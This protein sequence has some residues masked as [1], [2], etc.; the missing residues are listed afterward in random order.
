LREPEGLT[1]REI[2]EVT[3][4]L[5]R[6]AGFGQLSM[7]QI[8]TQLGVTATALYYH[9]R[10]K[11]ELLDQVA[12]HIMASLKAPDRALRWTERLRQVVLT[13]QRAMLTYPGL[14][15][16]L[17]Y[18]RESAG[19]LHWMEMILEVL[20][21]A[22]FSDLETARAL[23]TLSFFVH[24]LTLVDDRPHAHAEHMYRLRISDRRLVADASKYPHLK[25]LLPALA[26]HSYDSYLPLALDAVIAGIAARHKPR[27]RRTARKRAS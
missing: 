25:A 6:K 15:R 16:F 19:A 1:A 7:R 21:D 10:D 23:A 13:Q 14:A 20:R 24:P 27:Q 3:L 2:I 4:G 17:I 9:F 5:A 11:N 26:R 18:H 12:A 22:G 8:A